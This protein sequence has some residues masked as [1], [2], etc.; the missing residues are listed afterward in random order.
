MSGMTQIRQTRGVPAKR[1]GRVKYTGHLDG[2]PRE[3]TIKSAKDGYLYII[4]D[5]EKFARPY[6]P[7]WK[8]EYL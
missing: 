1:G 4:L 3:G 5:G 7:T 6:H 2:R 8:L